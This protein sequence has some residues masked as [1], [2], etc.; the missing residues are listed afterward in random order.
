MKPSINSQKSPSDT[1]N[2]MGSGAYFSS[3]SPSFHDVA[4]EKEIAKLLKISVSWL[5]KA[6]VRGDGPPFI[7]ISGGCI[8]YQVSAVQEWLQSKIVHSTSE[9]PNE[10]K[11]GQ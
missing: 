10:T 1:K 2:L 6:R 8:R 4:T 3:Q 11:G 7:R 5:Q 9:Y